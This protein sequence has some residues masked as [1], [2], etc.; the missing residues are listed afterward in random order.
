MLWV[1][2]PTW[3]LF[4]RRRLP[5]P[6]SAPENRIMWIIPAPATNHMR[7]RQAR[8][9]RHLKAVGFLK[10]IENSPFGWRMRYHTQF[11]AANVS[12]TG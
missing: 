12:T 10:L 11:I 1:L 6:G 2:V 7:M 4:R 9:G 5:L 8:R 3:A